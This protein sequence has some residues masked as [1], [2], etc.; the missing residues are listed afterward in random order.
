MAPLA[1]PWLRL[2]F[3]PPL[4][5]FLRAPLNERHHSNGCEKRLVSNDMDLV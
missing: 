5:I 4:G 2:F 1:T 3:G